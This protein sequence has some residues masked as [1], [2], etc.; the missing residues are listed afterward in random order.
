MAFNLNDFVMKTIIGMI[1]ANEPDYRVRQ[2]ALKWYEKEVLTDED[3]ITIETLI[4]EKN[5]IEDEIAEEM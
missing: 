3:L 2:Y 1:E 5:A 4:A